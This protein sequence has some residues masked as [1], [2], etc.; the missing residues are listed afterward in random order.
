MSNLLNVTEASKLI[1]PSLSTL[2][3]DIKKGKISVVVDE[4]GHKRID[5]AELSRVY[6][7]KKLDDNG[8]EMNT[9]ERSQ[10]GSMDSVDA[11]QNGSMIRPAPREN[12]S[13]DSV[14]TQVQNGSMNN[15]DAEVIDLLKSQID[16]LKK[17][18]ETLTEQIKEEKVEK[19]QILELADRLQKHADQLQLMLPPPPKAKVK[20]RFLNYFRIRK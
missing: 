12:G 19:A 18:N 15:V 5:P 13:V 17:Q 9:G 7:M 6:Q 8:G 4:R 10:N 14:D 2:R 1:V 16:D 3:R 11:A 20:G